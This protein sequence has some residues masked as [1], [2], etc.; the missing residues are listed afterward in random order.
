MHIEHSPFTT[1]MRLYDDPDGYAKR[2]PYNALLMAQW[3]SD[4]EVYLCCTHGEID[5]QVWKL[6]MSILK[7]EGVTKVSFERRGKLKTYEI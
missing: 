1:V 7:S 3:R 5:W 6:A 4:T 2:L